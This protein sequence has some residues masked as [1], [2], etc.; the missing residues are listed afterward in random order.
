[1]RHKFRKHGNDNKHHNYMYI[2]ENRGHRFISQTM[3]LM[4]DALHACRTIEYALYTCMTIVNNVNIS[5]YST[6]YRT[7]SSLRPKKKEYVLHYYVIAYYIQCAVCILYTVYYTAL[8]NNY[9]TYI[10]ILNIL[11]YI[12]VQR[13]SV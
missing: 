10:H 6:V 1:M 13:G 2:L 8:H 12:R 7:L 11:Q 5:G 3:T 9:I 4:R